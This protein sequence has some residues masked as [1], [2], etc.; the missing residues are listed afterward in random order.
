MFLIGEVIVEERVARED[1]ACDVVQCKGACCTLAG[2][3]GAPLQDDELKELERAFPAARKFLSEH[4][5]QTIERHGLYEGEPGAY[6]TTCVDENACAFVYY[7]EGIARCSFEKAFFNGE[8]SWRKPRSCHLFP[9]RIS[10]NVRETM[11]YEEIPECSSGLA[12][13]RDKHIPLYEFLKDAL[14]Q[15]YG[16]AWY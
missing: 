3:R 16:Q 1:F 10:K 9:V 6:A 11:R 7:Q 8:T 5:L 12:N 2:G 15:K 13:G 4:H 14:V